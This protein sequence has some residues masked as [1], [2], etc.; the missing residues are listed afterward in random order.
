[1]EINCFHTQTP[2]FT[3]LLGMHNGSGMIWVSAD[4]SLKVSYQYQQI[5][6][7]CR[8]LKVMNQL[9][10]LYIC[11]HQT[12]NKVVEFTVGQPDLLSLSLVL[13]SSLN[14]K[15]LVCKIVNYSE[16]SHWI[17][18]WAS[19]IWCFFPVIIQKH[20]RCKL[21]KPVEWTVPMCE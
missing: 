10:S 13:C 6:H 17:L 19:V 15:G 16:S 3:F 12:Y 21:G 20:A 11:K 9:I 5:W 2:M 7:I 8:Y 18:G 1:M 14:L 4:I